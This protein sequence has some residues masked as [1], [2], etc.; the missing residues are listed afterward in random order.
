VS[1]ELQGRPQ[2]IAPYHE[3]LR[4]QGIW[5]DAICTKRV[6]I[7]KWQDAANP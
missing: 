2:D 3:E 1:P 4:R 6:N 7:E 5:P